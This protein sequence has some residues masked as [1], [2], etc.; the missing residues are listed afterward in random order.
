M[1]S[2]GVCTL[3]QDGLVVL[4]PDGD[5]EWELLALC[6]DHGGCP[7]QGLPGGLG[8]RITK[9]LLALRSSLHWESS[10]EVCSASCQ[11]FLLSLI[12]L[13]II[14]W[15]CQTSTSGWMA[16]RVA[17]WTQLHLMK[18]PRYEAGFSGISGM[19]PG[20]WL[21]QDSRERKWV[22]I[23]Q[24]FKWGPKE[25]VGGAHRAHLPSQLSGFF[26]DTCYLPCPCEHHLWLLLGRLM[27][28][29]SPQKIS[30]S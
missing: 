14:I 1:L 25:T 11:W 18:W 9:E 19:C 12:E 21:L 28:I 6:W 26:C 20:G 3:K 10:E 29:L 27:W 23:C 5:N 8:T 30:R 7:W 22:Q 16:Q 13:P 15:F 17:N 24:K 2:L 4:C